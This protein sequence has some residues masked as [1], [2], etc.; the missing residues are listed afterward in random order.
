MTDVNSPSDKV[1]Y[2]TSDTTYSVK[3]SEAGT[4]TMDVEVIWADGIAQDGLADWYGPTIIVGDGGSVTTPDSSGN[5]ETT[6][7]EDD[8]PSVPLI[9]ALL[10]TSI[11]A[12]ARR[13]R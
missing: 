3:F 13:Q 7:T 5:D 6:L 2:S 1:E 8:L 11:V 12:I 9:V 4:Y 10:V